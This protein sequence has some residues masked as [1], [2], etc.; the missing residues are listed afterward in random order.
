M[1]LLTCS[2]STWYLKLPFLLNFLPQ[3]IRV[4][5]Q[6]HTVNIQHKL[7]Q[8]LRIKY[9]PI[10]GFHSIPGELKDNNGHIGVQLQKI[11]HQFLLYPTSYTR[12]IKASNRLARTNSKRFFNLKE[13]FHVGNKITNSV[14]MIFSSSSYTPSYAQTITGFC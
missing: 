3:Q 12:H 14:N 6:Q 5:L 8:L 13:L 10:L 11:D 7:L 4:G 1:N 2:F 9:I